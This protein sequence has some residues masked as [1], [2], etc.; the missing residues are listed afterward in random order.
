MK[1]FIRLF[2]VVLILSITWIVG[3]K[4]SGSDNGNG[5]PPSS[6]NGQAIIYL[7]QDCNVGNIDVTIGNTIRQIRNYSSLG[8]DCDADSSFAIFSLKPGTY[9]VTAKGGQQTWNG[10]VTVTTGQCTSLQLACDGTTP[11]VIGLAGT[12][13]FNLQHSTGLDFDLHV[14][15]PDGNEINSYNT[16]ASN[17]KLDLQSSCLGSDT[18][19]GFAGLTLTNENIWFSQGK[20]LRGTYKFWVQFSGTCASSL[21]GNYTLRVMDGLS[22]LNTYTGTLTSTS[23]KSQVYTFV[24]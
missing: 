21:S 3:C 4:K 18:N 1:H 9:S 14:I 8:P 15:A 22:I 5:Q 11:V 20:A 10:N 12:P 13:R 24:Y 19:Y 16:S 7:K 6:A 23:T 2:A 17:G